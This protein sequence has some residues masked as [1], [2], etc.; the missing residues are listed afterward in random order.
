L[1]FLSHAVFERE[2]RGRGQERG[3]KF[4]DVSQE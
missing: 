4:I 1:L 3:E 2:R